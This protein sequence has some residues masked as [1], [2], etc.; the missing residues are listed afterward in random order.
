MYLFAVKAIYQCQDFIKLIP[1]T[2]GF[3]T[4]LIFDALSNNNLVIILR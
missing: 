1:L 4:D 2:E 3:G